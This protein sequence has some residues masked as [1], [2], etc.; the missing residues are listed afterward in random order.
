MVLD[1]DVNMIEDIEGIGL[2]EFVLQKDKS[3]YMI[4]D[5]D[6]SKRFKQFSS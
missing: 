4:T 3:V 1:R 5:E 2:V 6:K